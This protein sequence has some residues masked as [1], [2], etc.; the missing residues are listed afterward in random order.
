MLELPQKPESTEM[1]RRWWKDVAE[2]CETSPAF[3]RCQVLISAI[4]GYKDVIESQIEVV[5]L[6]KAA[7]S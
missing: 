4:R 3:P 1:F 7:D 2:Y 5:A 6:F